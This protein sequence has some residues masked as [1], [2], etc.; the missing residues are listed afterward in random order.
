MC[1]HSTFSTT[2]HLANMLTKLST[3]KNLTILIIILLLLNTETSFNTSVNNILDVLNPT[4]IQTGLLLTAGIAYETQTLVNIWDACFEYDG[5]MFPAAGCCGTVGMAVG[6]W[7]VELAAFG[8]V[9][10]WHQKDRALKTGTINVGDFEFVF[11]NLNHRKHLNVVKDVGY[12]Q[13]EYNDDKYTYSPL[14]SDDL[15]DGSSY[16][17]MLNTELNASVPVTMLEANSNGTWALCPLIKKHNDVGYKNIDGAKLI[18]DLEKE[19][20]GQLNSCADA[21]NSGLT[22]EC[23][24]ALLK[25]YQGYIEQIFDKPATKI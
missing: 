24:T 25:V 15:S 7:S 10:E 6:K 11:I 5:D 4:I 13:F 18:I 1:G 12:F 21:A 17:L 23:L 14:M 9:I 19:Y 3:A 2:H 8:K 22:N 20:H 16:L